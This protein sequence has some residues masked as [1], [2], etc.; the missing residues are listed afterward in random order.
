[1]VE[2]EVTCRCHP[3]YLGDGHVCHSPCDYHNGGCHDNASC[4]FQVGVGGGG[5][6]QYGKHFQTNCRRTVRYITGTVTDIEILVFILLLH[7]DRDQALL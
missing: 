7:R 2:D 5:F 1:M 3:G 6:C 4:E